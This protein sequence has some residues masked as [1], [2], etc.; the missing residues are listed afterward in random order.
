MKTQ[1]LGFS[2]FILLATTTASWAAATAED[3]A[4]IQATFQSYLSAEPGVVTVTP[5]GDG[6]DIALDVTPF[7]LKNP[8]AGFTA[9]ID[10]Y[11][12]KAVPQGNGLWSVTSS[13]PYAASAS[14]PGV[15][16]FTM[17]TPSIEWSGTYNDA[18]LAF[19][20]SKYNVSKLSISQNQTDVNT[21]MVTKGA[22][23]IESMAVET[24]GIDVGG[25]L[26]DSQSTVTF[27]GL[28]SSTTVEIPPE[29][30][31]AGMPNINYVANMTKGSYL[32]DLKGMNSKTLMD[33]A[34]F[35]VAHPSKELVIKDQQ[36]LKDKLLAALPFF[37]SLQS[38]GKFENLTVDTS[39]GQ[40]AI[41]DG[42]SNVGVNG[43]VKDGRLAEGF[44]INGFKLPD[45]L[46]LPPWS[47]G[48]IPTKM[49][50]G[51]EV[52]GF[53]M[54]APARKFFSEMDVSQK[55][56]VPPGSEAAYMAAFSP[57]N[58]IVVTIPPGGISA[59]LFSL[60]YEGKSTVN[61]AGL[62]Q[63]NAK[64][65]MT[66]M[67]KVIA[68]LQQAATDPTAQQGMAML[69]AAKGIGKADGDTV[70]WDVT[71]SP[72]G[73]LLVNGTDLSSMMGALSPPPPPPPQ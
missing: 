45:G 43:A 62:P 2:L 23:V 26:V 56:P 35:F 44:E 38:D 51:F 34:A 9:K 19:M 28:V 68:Q 3:A 47:K 21:K 5:A 31:A 16:D 25:G 14:V 46:P 64:F 71:M 17:N 42:G 50:L 39:Y 54:E 55:D 63:V 60:T 69:F 61:F 70:T 15:F 12:F 66:G 48:L 41:T 29:M 30:A 20:D 11:K 37:A 1:K 32:S 27:N 72:E 65:S 57:T 36:I 59:D 67:D 53:D 22:T 33:I 8:Q 10:P 24:K 73:K 58:S 18:L 4:R 52:S 40:F 13:G 7:L 6:Y 49:K